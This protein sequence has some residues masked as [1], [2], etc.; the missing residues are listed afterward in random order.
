MTWQEALDRLEGAYSEQTLRSYRS[1]FA[2]FE[3]WC[4]ANSFCSLP[5]SPGTLAAFIAA[6]APELA[7]NTLRR[8]LAGIRKVHR[9]FHLQNPAENEEVLI[10]MRRA[11][12]SKP[13]RPRQALGLT[14]KSSEIS[15]SP[16]AAMTLPAFAT[17]R[18]SWSVTTPC[19]AD[20]NSPPYGSKT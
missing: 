7:A 9:L 4:I 20:R 6:Q 14:P 19:V 15:S 16:P 1:D 5:A 10:A 13:G 12:R 3:S 11:L 18:L 2:I 17:E 8:R